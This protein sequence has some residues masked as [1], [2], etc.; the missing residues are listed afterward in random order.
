M[1]YNTTDQPYSTDGDWDGLI[2]T[3]GTLLSIQNMT[4]HGKLGFQ[5]KPSKDF[6]VPIAIDRYFHYGRQGVMGIAHY[7]RG[8]MWVE[9]YD[10]VHKTPR[11]SSRRLL[12]LLNDF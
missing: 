11:G 10:D 2:Y 12:T 9:T 7:E 3:N 1:N 8:L 6:E 4:W 5:E